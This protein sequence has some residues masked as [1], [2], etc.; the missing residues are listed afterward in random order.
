MLIKII[1]LIAERMKSKKYNSVGFAA[2]CRIAD[3][4][5]HDGRDIAKAILDGDEAKVKS[6]LCGVVD[7][8]ASDLDFFCGEGFSARMKEYVNSVVW[9]N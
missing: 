1:E 4:I 9:T 3:C 8:Q 6:L 5:N 7:R 2:G